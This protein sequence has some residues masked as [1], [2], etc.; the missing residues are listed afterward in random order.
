MLLQVIGWYVNGDRCAGAESIALAGLECWGS[1]QDWPT[2][3]TAEEFRRCAKLLETI[4]G[5]QDVA[6]KHL[7]AVGGDQW[8]TLID[9]WNEIAWLLNDTSIAGET[10]EEREVC[11][12]QRIERLMHR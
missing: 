9:N 12:T 11:L 8:S 7:K 5:L 4:P 2:P 10:D 1:A 3:E 6:F